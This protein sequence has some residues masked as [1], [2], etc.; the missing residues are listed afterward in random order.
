M[1]LKHLPNVIGCPSDG[2]EEERTN[3][4]ENFSV[5][6]RFT[7]NGVA[8]RPHVEVSKRPGHVGLIEEDVHEEPKGECKEWISQSSKGAL[9]NSGWAEELV[10]KFLAAF[11]QIFPAFSKVVGKTWNIYKILI[12]GFLGLQ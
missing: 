7:E 10:K 8:H 3:V 1:F 4:S 11:I 9:G 6:P 2:S 12:L 5:Q